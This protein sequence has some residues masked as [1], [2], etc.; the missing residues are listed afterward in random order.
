MLIFQANAPGQMSFEQVS[1]MM[2]KRHQTATLSNSTRNIRFIENHIYACLEGGIHVYT[3]SL[4]RVDTIEAADMGD[5]RD[6]CSVPSGGFVVA[7]TKGLYQHKDNG[8]SV[9]DRLAYQYVVLIAIVLHLF[10]L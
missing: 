6:V 4:Q 7:A 5:V 3:T 2:W 8:V 1:Q 9:N 10:I